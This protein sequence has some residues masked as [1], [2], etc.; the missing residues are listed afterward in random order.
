MQENYSFS[1]QP[2]WPHRIDHPW[3]GSLAYINLVFLINFK[4]LTCKSQVRSQ[5]PSN[6]IQLEAESIYNSPI[7]DNRQ[8]MYRMFW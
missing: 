2:A 8:I 3:I 7:G 1:R 6:F 4:G 5:L